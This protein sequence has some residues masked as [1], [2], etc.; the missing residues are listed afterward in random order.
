MQQQ[1][2]NR[3]VYELDGALMLA[4]NVASCH[5]Q[6]AKYGPQKTNPDMT[7]LVRPQGPPATARNPDFHPPFQPKESCPD[8]HQEETL[9]KLAQQLRHIGDSIHRRTVEEGLQQE[10]RDALAHFALFLFGRAR[11]VLRLLWN[12]RLL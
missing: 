7:R 12:P 2:Q 8:C 6:R 4:V 5:L 11:A 10:G 1:K 3:V 9:R